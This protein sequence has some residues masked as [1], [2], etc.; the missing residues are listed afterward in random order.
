MERAIV[1]RA[2]L[3]H[4]TTRVNKEPF[5]SLPL[6]SETSLSWASNTRSLS[7]AEDRKG[8]SFSLFGACQFGP[9]RVECCRLP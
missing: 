9:R 4:R 2:I 8:S 6:S 3:K 1:C 5:S 7:A